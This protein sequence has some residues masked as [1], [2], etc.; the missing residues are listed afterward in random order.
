MIFFPCRNCTIDYYEFI[1]LR[2]LLAQRANNSITHIWRDDTG[3][4]SI[5][6]RKV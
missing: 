1:D 3:Q 6:F 5:H 2:L 4:S